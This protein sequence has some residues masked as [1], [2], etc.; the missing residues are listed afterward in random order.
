MTQRVYERGVYT[1]PVWGMTQLLAAAGPF[2]ARV[3]A[4]SPV[5]AEASIYRWVYYGWPHFAYDR[6]FAAVWPTAEMD[7]G[8][9]TGGLTN[10]LAGNGAL[11]VLLSDRFRRS[12]RD[13]MLDGDDF[14]VWLDQVHEAVIE[15]PRRN[16]LLGIT[17]IRTLH[18]P[19]PAGNPFDH[20]EAMWIVEYGPK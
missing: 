18:P 5:A 7:V 14:A 2:Q 3:G 6:P 13:L 16:E 20:F 10:F 4:A 8:M 17:A 11:S 15:H 9:W 19:A 12:D 1:R